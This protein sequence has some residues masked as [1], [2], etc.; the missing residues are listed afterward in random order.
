MDEIELSIII[1]SYNTRKL[2]RDCINSIV[3]NVKSIGYEII[4]IDNASDD[5]S[6]EFVKSLTRKLPIKV[7][8]NKKNL[9]FGQAHN[10]GMKISKGKYLLLLNSDTI[11]ENNF[12]P[13]MIEWMDNNPK[14]GV[15]SCSLVNIDGGMQGTGGYFPTLLRVISWMTIQDLPFVDAI[16]KPFHPMKDKSFDKGNKFYRSEKELDWVTGAF[17]LLRRS[18]FEEVG[19]FDEDYFMYTEEVD[20]CFRLKER[21]WRVFYLPKW[22][23]THLGGASSSKESAVLNEYNGI[24][25]FYKK[26][27][28][29]FHYCLLRFFLK[30][31]ALWRMIIFGIIKG[32]PSFKI[33]A[34]AFREA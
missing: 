34:K 24:K 15:S 30:I 17:F 33:Y 28:P 20:Y 32:F 7:I 25:L 9:G 2:L 27:Y 18:A 3:D 19:Y 8:E 4:V 21:N 14:V 31:G 23:V 6:L 11:L 12:L 10:K 22:K 5:G 16:I 1:V 29:A 26:H 13:E